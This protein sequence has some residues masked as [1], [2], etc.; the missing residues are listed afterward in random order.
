MAFSYLMKY[1]PSFTIYKKYFKVRKF[2]TIYSNNNWFMGIWVLKLWSQVSFSFFFRE[3]TFVFEKKIEKTRK[4]F[5]RVIP[6]LGIT[7]KH[8]ELEWVKVKDHILH[9]LLREKRSNNY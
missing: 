5:F 9:G 6:F 1:S 3:I 8:W 4:C 2:K 7:Q